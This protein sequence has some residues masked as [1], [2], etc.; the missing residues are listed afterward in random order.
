[1]QLMQMYYVPK[2][3]RDHADSECV[4]RVR[5]DSKGAEFTGNKHTH[6]DTQLYILVQSIDKLIN[7]YIP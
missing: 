4:F 7:C 5:R 3:S 2:H 1:M 6:T